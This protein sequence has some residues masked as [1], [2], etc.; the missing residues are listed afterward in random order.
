MVRPMVDRTQLQGLAR[1]VESLRRRL[2]E[3]HLRLEQVDAVLAEHDI[4]SQV[5]EALLA[6]ENPSHASSQVSIGSGVSLQYTHEGGDEGVALIDLGG[7]VFGERHWSDAKSITEERRSDIQHLRDELAA[8]AEQTETN[9]AEVAKTF[10]AAAE[11]LQAKA[12]PPQSTVEPTPPGPKEPEPPSSTAPPKRNRKRG[13]FGG[14][15]TL[16]D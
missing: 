12:Q 15:L 10:N 7:G 1:D 3:I 6:H 2:D 5:L 4:T 8:Q 16:D 9:L 14:D 11:Q 13:M